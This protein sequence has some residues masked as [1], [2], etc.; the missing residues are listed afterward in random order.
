MGVQEIVQLYETKA[1]GSDPKGS[2]SR[3]NG[4]KP[5]N[6]DAEI[7][8][9]GFGPEVSPTVVQE[10]ASEP[11]DP[12]PSPI[13]HRPARFVRH[14][15]F[16]PHYQRVKTPDIPLR[17][18]SKSPERLQVENE[19][20]PKDRSPT[21]RLVERAQTPVQSD[22]NE[23][24]DSSYSDVS[25]L[26]LDARATKLVKQSADSLAASG[27]AIDSVVDDGA[28]L[29]G[30]HS[31]HMLPTPKDLTAAVH[32][33][34]PAPTLFGRNTAPLYLPKLDK[35]LSLLPAPSFAK[36]KAKGKEKDVPMF[37]PMDQLAASKRTIDD[38]EHNSTITPAWRDVNFWFSLANDAVIG[39]VVRQLD[40]ALGARSEPS[41][42]GLERPRS[43]L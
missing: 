30:S 43:L 19:G 5:R 34:V 25:T 33:P 7:M 32:R 18:L 10:P 2:L 26:R 41:Y 29:A 21:P 3:R 9:P 16:Q 31:T 22:E 15:L 27:T 38:L 13:P 39:V 6:S 35:Y 8:P 1:S 36:W 12:A 23:L 42:L 20:L 37:P 28:T 11:P 40:C 14:P 24:L 17:V 4:Y